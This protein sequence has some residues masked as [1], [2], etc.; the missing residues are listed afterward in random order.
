MLKIKSILVSTILCGF[1]LS[2]VFCMPIH[3]TENIS[4][5]TT[6]VTETESGTVIEGKV[7]A[8]VPTTIQMSRF[9]TIDI[10][11]QYPAQGGRWDYGFLWLKVRSYYTVNKYSGI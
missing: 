10:H 6:T 9:L 7:S 8:M 1:A 4:A 3:A 11:S 5:I 2:L